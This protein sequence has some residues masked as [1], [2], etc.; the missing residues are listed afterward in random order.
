MNIVGR[1]TLSHVDYVF[2]ADL[3]AWKQLNSCFMF[4]YIRGRKLDILLYS[5]SEGGFAESDSNMMST[6]EA[7]EFYSITV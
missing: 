5:S 4:I 7:I 3:S 6:L 1:K 2:C